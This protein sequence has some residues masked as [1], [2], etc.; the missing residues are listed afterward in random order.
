MRLIDS[1][2]LSVRLKDLLGPVTR[3]KKK[4]KQRVEVC[5]RSEPRLGCRADT[6]GVARSGNCRVGD[7]F[8]P[9]GNPGTN[10]WFL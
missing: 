10:R 3:V 4:K 1:C 5:A 2:I 6:P 9:G 7:T 8:R